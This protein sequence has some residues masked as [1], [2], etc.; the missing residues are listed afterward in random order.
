MLLTNQNA[1]IVACILLAKLSD[2]EKINLDGEITVEECEAI[3]I[4]FW[5]DDRLSQ[6]AEVSSAN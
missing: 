5:T 3:L 6:K 2:E 4:K 1:E